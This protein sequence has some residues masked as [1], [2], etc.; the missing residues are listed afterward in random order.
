MVA[1]LR[2]LVLAIK[3][4]C[5]FKIPKELN[6][7][8]I[9]YLI[10]PPGEIFGVSRI[11]GKQD[12]KQ[13]QI[14]QLNGLTP[15][16][17]NEIINKMQQSF[18]VLFR[19]NLVHQSY[20]NKMYNFIFIINQLIVGVQ[21]SDIKDSVFDSDIKRLL[22]LLSKL[23]PRLYAYKIGIP[24]I[25]TLFSKL[26]NKKFNIYYTLIILNEID[27]KSIFS[28]FV[29]T[30]YIFFD[31]GNF[32]IFIPLICHEIN[33]KYDYSHLSI[34]LN[35]KNKELKIIHQTFKYYRPIIYFFIFYFLDKVID[36]DDCTKFI[37]NITELS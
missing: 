23:L 21:L 7:I 14:C 16:I 4:L 10:G 18:N 37:S 11:L 20:M 26:I 13:Y 3:Y 1:G 19:C 2:S 29:N 35:N 24:S 8:V 17:L 31:S 32:N 33:V 25:L 36:L 6:S 28:V 12:F 5:C 22:M 27:K 15:Q 34:L 9:Q 30:K